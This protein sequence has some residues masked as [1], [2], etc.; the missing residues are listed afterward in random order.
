MHSPVSIQ[1][2]SNWF[3]A[4]EVSGSNA[5]GCEIRH[6]RAFGS[7]KLRVNRPVGYD[8]VLLSVAFSIPRNGVA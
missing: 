8:S 6:N 1:A 7:A 3:V 4:N 5:V 2:K